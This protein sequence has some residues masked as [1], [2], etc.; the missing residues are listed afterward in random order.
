M[1]VLSKR[2]KIQIALFTILV[3]CLM[4]LLAFAAPVSPA[5]QVPPGG[6][7][8][9]IKYASG[10]SYE[11]YG[12]IGSLSNTQ[13]TIVDGNKLTLKC[14]YIFI[15]YD[16][17]ILT[18]DLTAFYTETGS[19]TFDFSDVIRSKLS[20]HLDNFGEPYCTY[21]SVHYTIGDPD[22]WTHIGSGITQKNLDSGRTVDYVKF[23]YIRVTSDPSYVPLAF[24]FI[25]ISY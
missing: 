4:P 1:K 13:S 8:G 6:G 25:Y 17:D 3:G 5:A 24:D 23:T 19:I 15:G 22:K 12:I 16:R 21:L 10:Y 18:G 7:S 14:T 11:G 9:G 2:V 20:F